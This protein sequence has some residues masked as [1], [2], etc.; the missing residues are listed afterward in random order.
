MTD[1][2]NLKRVNDFLKSVITND[3]NKL[4]FDDFNED[5]K[6]ISLVMINYLVKST[7]N[8]YELGKQL[9]KIFNTIK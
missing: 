7:P 5:E 6:S 9:R 3:K 1:S 8:D 4:S 2:I